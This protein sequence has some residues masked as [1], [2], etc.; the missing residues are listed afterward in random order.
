M[1]EL[2]FSEFPGRITL[3]DVTWHCERHGKHNDVLTFI[4][5]YEGTRT[6]CMYCLI[7]VLDMLGLS[8]LPRVD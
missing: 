2:E 8:D 3:R 6:I 1:S 5:Q 4:T 7:D